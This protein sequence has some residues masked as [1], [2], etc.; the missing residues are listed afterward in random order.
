MTK[1]AL[2]PF[3]PSTNKKGAIQMRMK[4]SKFTKTAPSKRLDGTATGVGGGQIRIPLKKESLMAEHQVRVQASQ[5][6]GTNF[7]SSSDVRRFITNV[8]IET[9][10]GRRVFLT[11]YQAIDLAK[12]TE[13]YPSVPVTTGTAGGASGGVASTADFQFAIHHQND[14]AVADMLAA[15]PAGQLTTFD[16]VLDLAADA[17]NGFIGGTGTIGVTS[18]TATA[19]SVGY[20]DMLQNAQGAINPFVGTLRHI[21][22]RQVVQ[23]TAGAGTSFDV[24][25]TSGNLTRFLMIHTF[26]NTGAAAVLSD[27]VMNNIRVVI[28]GEEKHISTFLED[29][30]SNTK[31]RNFNYTGVIVIDFGDDEAGWLNLQGVAEPKLTFD[32]AGSPPANWIVTVAQDY[33][34]RMK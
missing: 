8:A 28:N 4:N 31:E 9:S 20:P 22:E 17:N 24:R 32:V 6:Y 25:L 11:G 18:Y 12:L 10:D 13:T 1:W 2:A 30:K 27:A 21:A 19:R 14:G 33:S 26:D 3:L 34:V 15:I 23:S 16:L 5:I 7:P 29:R